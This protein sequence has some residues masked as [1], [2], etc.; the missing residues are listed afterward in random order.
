MVTAQLRRGPAEAGPAVV[1]PGKV[2][3]P[4]K[5]AAQLSARPSKAR[6]QPGARPSEACG[7]V[8]ELGRVETE[9]GCRRRSAIAG[10]C[11]LRTQGRLSIVERPAVGRGKGIR[12]SRDEENSKVVDLAIEL[13]KID[14][15]GLIRFARTSRFKMAVLRGNAR[16]DVGSSGMVV[17]AG[18]SLVIG[19]NCREK[20][21]A[22]QV[23]FRCDCQQL[24][25]ARDGASFVRSRQRGMMT[26]AIGR[27]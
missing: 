26:T 9:N 18:G 16:R 6:G 20:I 11:S 23:R 24:Q 10:I 4:T 17:A 27:R 14:G 12:R 15:R 19:R 21:S 7:P 5:R 3:G 2:G 22:I 25:E 8:A 13:M 1:R